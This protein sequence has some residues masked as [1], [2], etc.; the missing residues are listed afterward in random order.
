MFLL[1]N[2]EKRLG[3]VF[4]FQ[5]V[6]LFEILQHCYL[7]SITLL[8]AVVRRVQLPFD[9]GHLVRTVGAVS[10]HDDR[11]IKFTGDVLVV[12]SFESVFD[13]FK[14]VVDTQKLGNVI[15]SKVSSVLKDP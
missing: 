15:Y 14:A 10:C 12:V 4:Y 6:I 2:L 11:A 8:E 5:I 1:L 13:L 3:G 7:T 9:A